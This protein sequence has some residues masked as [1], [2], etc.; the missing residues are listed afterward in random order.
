MSLLAN[1]RFPR[2]ILP[3]SALIES[4]I[5]FLASL[6]VFYALA[7]PVDGILPGWQLLALPG[8]LAL[9]VM[10]NLGLAAVTARL[11]I[12]FRDINN[13]I[14]HFTRLWLYLSPIIW[15]ISFVTDRAPWAADWLIVNPMVPIVDLYRWVLMG[16][17]LSSSS[18]V[19][20]VVWAAVIFVLGIL[21]FVRFEGNMVRHI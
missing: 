5:G 13:L 11:V 14:P 21:S 8:V 9:H 19:G 10:F 18:I 15:P 17:A 6:L 20:S 12:P 1:I 3:I 16:D 7:I 4:T 2:L